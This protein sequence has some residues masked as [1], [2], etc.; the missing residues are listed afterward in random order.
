M[1]RPAG[2]GR[3][4]LCKSASGNFCGI[5]IYCLIPSNAYNVIPSLSRKLMR[6]YKGI[7]SYERKIPFVQVC[8]LVVQVRHS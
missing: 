4:F 6:N 1:E 3:L 2:N 7:L 5:P 8:K